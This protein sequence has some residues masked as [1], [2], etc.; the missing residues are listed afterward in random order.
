M[1]D[2]ENQIDRPFS[3]SNLSS[4][5]SGCDIIMGYSDMPSCVEVQVLSIIELS[6]HSNIYN[7]IELRLNS[8]PLDQYRVI[9]YLKSVLHSNSV[10]HFI[11]IS[12]KTVDEQPLKSKYVSKELVCTRFAIFRRWCPVFE[13]RNCTLYKQSLCMWMRQKD[14]YN[15]KPQDVSKWMSATQ[16]CAEGCNHGH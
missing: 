2:L 12:N 14:I 5:R 15:K 4:E 1:N 8:Y 3:Q 13:A 11:N 7:W 6:I 16:N 9:H 10:L